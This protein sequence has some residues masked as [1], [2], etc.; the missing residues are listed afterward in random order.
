MDVE[1]QDRS[2]R[3]LL[4]K[5]K[6]LAGPRALFETEDLDDAE[7]VVVS[8]GITSRVAQRA[9]QLARARGIRAGKFRLISA[10][11]FPDPHI[12][13]LAGRVKAFVVPELNLGQM[14]HEVA[15]AA[16]GKAKVVPVSHAGGSVH[17]PEVILNAIVEAAR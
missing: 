16:E 10:W 4:D 7:V 8:Y 5:L 11:P 13:E 3:R 12:R 17:N 9:I 2:V 6:P 14:V 15:R 1:T